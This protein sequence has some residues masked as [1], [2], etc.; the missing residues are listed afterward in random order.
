[1]NAFGFQRAE[2]PLQV[3]VQVGRLRRLEDALRADFVDDVA[4]LLRELCVAVHE[5]VLLAVQETVVRSGQ[6]AGHDLHPRPIGIRRRSEE[7]DASRRQF[8]HKEQ[9]KGHQPAA[10]KPRR[11]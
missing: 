10:S 8:H 11:S 7:T 2:K 1:M 4:K 6:L 5:Q 9:I 3:G